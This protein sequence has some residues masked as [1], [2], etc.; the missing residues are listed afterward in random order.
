MRIASTCL[1]VAIVATAGPVHAAA[2]ERRASVEVDTSAVGEAGPIIQRRI[3][4]R[5]DVVLRDAEVLPGQDDDA[6]IRVS[7][8]ELT[9]DDPG[10]A[11]DLWVERAGEE[12]GE[13]R[14][15][16][17]NLC[18]ETE[19]VAKAE[20]EIGVV[21]SA[22]PVEPEADAVSSTPLDDDPTAGPMTETEHGDP[23][24]DTRVRLGPKGKAG[25]ALLV[26]GTVAAGVGIGLAIPEW[27]PVDGD[28]TREKSTRPIGIGLAAAG[29][30]VLVAG[31]VL[32]GLDRKASRSSKPMLSLSPSRRGVGIRLSGWF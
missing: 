11:F 31:A 3:E 22:L 18:T 7:V 10:F 13:R 1:A 21:V 9:G 6:V 2:P 5:A 28:P 19:I 8:K 24:A 25:I 15:V 29:G 20:S 26:T 27:K 16:E 17:C 12:V 30:A 23:S 32:L 14:R 4:E